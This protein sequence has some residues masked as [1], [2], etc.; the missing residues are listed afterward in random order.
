MQTSAK[1]KRQNGNL[2][3]DLCVDDHEDSTDDDDEE[4]IWL[5]IVKILTMTKQSRS[6]LRL[7][8]LHQ[9]F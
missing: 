2:D 1:Q 8:K 3:N 4:R 6:L 9:K 7:R 5:E